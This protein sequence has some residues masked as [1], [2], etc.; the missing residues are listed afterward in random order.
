M[1]DG[2]VISCIIILGVLAFTE[3]VYLFFLPEYENSDAEKNVD[4]VILYRP[5]DV[6]F[7]A[8]LRAFLA[9]ARWME[10]AFLSKIYVVHLHV[11]DVQSETVRSICAKDARVVYCSIDVFPT[12][13]LEEKNSV[14]KDCNFTEKGV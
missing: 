6:R 10:T 4:A 3:L 7:A 11:P 2:I 13:L 9:H 1:V 12:L 14:E 8:Q 5:E